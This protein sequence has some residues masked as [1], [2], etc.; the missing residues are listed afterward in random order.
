[1]IRT[2]LLTAFLLLGIL[3]HAQNTLMLAFY[4]QENLFD[5]ID[6]PERNDNE[7]LPTSKKSWNSEK[8]TAKLSNMSRVIA[9]MNS[10]KGPDVLGMCEVENRAVLQDLIGTATLKPMNYGIVHFESPDERSIDN[11][12]LYNKNVF[13]VVAQAAYR[14]NLS[15][16]ND[17]KTRDIVMAKLVNKK[18][19][20]LIVLVNHFPSRLGGQEAS[21]PKRIAAALVL[22]HIIDSVA[23]AD[24]ATPIIAM[25]DFNDEPT[26]S[27]MDSVLQ[28]KDSDKAGLYNAMYSL[29]Q[30]GEGSHMYQK[31]WTMLDQIL[32]TQNAVSCKSSF[33]Y[34]S[35]SATI[36]KQ[37]WMLETD[38]KYK[39]APLR[40]FAGN[41]YLN[42]FS[43]HLPVYILLKQK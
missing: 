43:D 13:T 42:G 5:T 12:V 17:A 31:N 25:G 37:D 40:T 7:F 10:G 34:V 27:S 16:F 4:N 21:E 36:Y 30:K 18:K 33:C 23:K 1:M 41:K 39:G 32:I 28:A 19:Q 35:Q 15:A 3:T 20:S 8:Y 11:A 38:E 29:K 26:N 2:S 22:K 6:D 24:P 14:I 9:S